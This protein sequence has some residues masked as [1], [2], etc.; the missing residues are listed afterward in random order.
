MKKIIILTLMAVSLLSQSCDKRE[1]PYHV[2]ERFIY[3][4]YA[5]AT[6]ERKISYSFVVTNDNVVEVAIPIKYSGYR[7]TE[8]SPYAIRVED[9]AEDNV[10]AG[11]LAP[12]E[13][14]LP[15]EMIFRKGLFEDV[16]R[17]SIVRSE[18][19]KSGVYGLKIALAS[20]DYFQ[21]TM[22]NYLETTLYISDILSKPIWW[23]PSVTKDYLGEYGDLKY[24]LFATEI[25]SGDFGELE[26][27]DKLF[28][29]R[30][31]KR[32][33]DDNPTIDPITGLPITVPVKG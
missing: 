21:A 30:R 1:V 14:I 22:R 11:T 7:L 31:F 3:I 24:K 23:T 2:D 17:I 29:A 9:P 6:E 28:Y 20:N 12:T 10:L 4:N 32:Y 25:Y 18:R 19:M 5:T 13:Y 27:V 15:K 16:L 33:L 26:D 8:D